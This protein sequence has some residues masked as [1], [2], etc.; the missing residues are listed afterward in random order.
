MKI[1]DK[2]IK[3]IIAEEGFRGE[4]YQDV[5]GVDTI[6]FGFTKFKLDGA[7]GLP[8][9]EEF[10]DK[11]MTEEEALSYL[12]I[13][14]EEDLNAIKNEINNEEQFDKLNE[15]QIVALLDLTYRNGMG[16]MRKTD[17]FNLIREDEFNKISEEIINNE[18]LI[19]AGGEQTDNIGIINRTNTNAEAFKN[20]PEFDSQ[21]K[22]DA[23]NEI[24][25]IIS[26]TLYTNNEKDLL[27]KNLKKI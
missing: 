19:K 24:D 13:I 11:E 26:S 21:D 10:R 18:N 8:E 9:I 23:Y 27:R 3:K 25:K 16:N 15:D 14:L 22:L 20:I 5:A 12:K 1:T 7:R 6:G 2:I 4:I 17:I